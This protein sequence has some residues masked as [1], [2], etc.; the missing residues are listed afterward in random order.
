MSVELG[1]GLS[2]ENSTAARK[3]D[4]MEPQLKIDKQ[5]SKSTLVK[6]TAL[7]IIITVLSKLIGFGREVTLAYFFGANIATDAYIVATT[8]PAVLFLAVGEAIKD[9]FI[10]VY[11]R[12]RAYGRDKALVYRFTLIGT[13]ICIL[14]II[15]P[16]FLNTNFV[17]RLLAPKL[18]EEGIALAE[19]MLRVLI[20]VVLFRLFVSV[21]T[22]ILH[23]NRNFLI[24]GLIGIHTA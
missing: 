21:G 12:F 19:S 8:I 16:V 22:A 2:H 5:N 18:P 9:A 23:V 17:I 3:E 24:P 7:L 6:S 10:P 13:I 11:D 4:I 14:V 20:F 15:L 1:Y